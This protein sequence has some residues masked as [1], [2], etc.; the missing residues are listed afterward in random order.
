MDLIKNI[1][2]NLSENDVKE[3]IAKHIKEHLG[4]VNITAEDVTLSVGM[5]CVGYG[6]MEHDVPKFREAIVRCKLKE[7]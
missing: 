4:Y 3:I 5:E 1:T 6:P 7:E 2:V